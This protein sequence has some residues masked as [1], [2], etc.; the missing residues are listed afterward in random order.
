MIEP[1]ARAH[2]KHLSIWI[3]Q[4]RNRELQREA[5]ASGWIETFRRG[6]AQ[7]SVAALLLARQIGLEVPH[8]HD[9]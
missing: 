3:E 5:H 4:Q 7:E 2:R 8:A 9:R 1:V 6:V